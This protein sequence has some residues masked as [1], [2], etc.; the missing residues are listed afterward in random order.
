MKR[1]RAWSRWKEKEERE[2]NNEM[3]DCVSEVETV[4]MSD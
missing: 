2:R 3:V 4:A 1:S